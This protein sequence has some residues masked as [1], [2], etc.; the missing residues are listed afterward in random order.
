M[1]KLQKDAE[2]VE[3]VRTIVQ[4]EEGIMAQETQIVQDYAQVPF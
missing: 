2:I 1:E 3:R 4:M